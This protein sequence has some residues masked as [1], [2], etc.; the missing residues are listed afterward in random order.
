MVARLETVAKDLFEKLQNA[1]NLQRRSASLAACETA[2][3]EV[4]L[5]NSF[6]FECLNKLKMGEYLSQKAVDSLGDIAKSL[7]EKYFELQDSSDVNPECQKEI[8]AYFSQARAVASI[9]FA[10]SD[11]NALQAASESIYEASMAFDDG[12]A[13]FAAAKKAMQL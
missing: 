5:E 2:L 9:V 12:N 11:T 10:A 7:D 8:M 3:M 13:V 4:H 1:S 6:A